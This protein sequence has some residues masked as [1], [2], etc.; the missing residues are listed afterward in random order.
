MAFQTMHED[1]VY[2]VG[3]HDRRALS[4]KVCVRPTAAWVWGFD[5]VAH[6]LPLAPRPPM[7]A[8]AIPRR[9]VAWADFV[10]VGGMGLGC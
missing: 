4:R 5:V 2:K 9:H 10:V 8:G 1:V 6:I 7:D 3:V